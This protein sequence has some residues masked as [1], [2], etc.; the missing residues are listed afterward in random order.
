MYSR[1]KCLI[2]VIFFADSHS[3]HSSDEKKGLH[4]FPSPK[5]MKID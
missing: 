2:K 1:A 4:F 5:I 3:E